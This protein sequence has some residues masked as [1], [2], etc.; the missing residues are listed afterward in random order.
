MGIMNNKTILILSDGMRPDA[1]IQ[2][3]HPVVKRFLEESYYS[4]TARTVMP[5]VTLPCHMSLFHSVPPDRHGILTNTYF[6]MVRPINGIMEVLREARK[7]CGVFYMWEELRDLWQPDSIAYSGYIS[8]HI[9]REKAAPRLTEE[10]IRYIKEFEPD[11][12]FLYF[13]E[14]D[15]MGHGSGWMGE[16]Y[17]YALE[18]AWSMIGQVDDA[19][20]GYNI[21]VTADHGGHERNHGT[22]L[23]EDMTIPIF[24]KGEGIAPGQFD[25]GSILDIAP[26]IAKLCGVMP[27]PEWEGKSLI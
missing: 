5:S 21:I 23:P 17:M 22:D 16:K 18:R 20:D 11:F 10:C 27:D 14:T 9:Y 3:G 24:I 26:T 15:A 4:M 13:A 8:G 12:V 7:N 2:S 6:Q 25:G 1:V 19:I